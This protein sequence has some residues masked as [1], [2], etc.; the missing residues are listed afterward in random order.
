[1]SKKYTWNELH[2]ID[3]LGSIRDDLTPE[4]DKALMLA[5]NLPN[6]PL[7]HSLL[8]ELDFEKLDEISLTKVAERLQEIYG[9]AAIKKVYD[10]HGGQQIQDE[11]ED[12]D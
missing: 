1:M 4:Q 12:E 7:T 5:V 2:E 11:R 6:D 8:F 3:N 9:D 10:N